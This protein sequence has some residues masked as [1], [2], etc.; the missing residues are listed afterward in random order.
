[1]T[2]PA[3][4]IFERQIKD[5]GL[6]EPVKEFLFYDG[7]KWRF[8]FAWPELQLAFEIIVSPRIKNISV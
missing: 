3:I 7:R 5:H 1:M 8:D 2:R 6:P 4:E